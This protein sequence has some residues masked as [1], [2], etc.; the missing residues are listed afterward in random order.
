[1]NHPNNTHYL[2]FRTDDDEIVRWKGTEKQYNYLM[3]QILN[4]AQVI[5]LRSTLN[6]TFSFK[7]FTGEGGKLK[8]AFQKAQPSLPE[9][10]LSET[11]REGRKKAHFEREVQWAME[12][13]QWVRPEAKEEAERRKK[14]KNLL[15]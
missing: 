12:G 5:D 2:D 14:A 10:P 3:K 1:M 7:H 15:K 9:A 8:G 6:R 13:K 4:F 11:E